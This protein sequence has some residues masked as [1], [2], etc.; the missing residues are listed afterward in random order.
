MKINKFEV[1]GEFELSADNLLTGWFLTP[2]KPQI[3]YALE[4]DMTEVSETD[5]GLDAPP[6]AL[7]VRAL[8]NAD[9]NVLLGKGTTIILTDD[10]GRVFSTTYD[11]ID[12]FAETVAD[13]EEKERVAMPDGKVET[14]TEGKAEGDKNESPKKG[15]GG[16][17]P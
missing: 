16:K 2:A 3:K 9:D 14:V 13:A 5:A 10:R 17:K 6:V 15:K 4:L 1:E 12:A 11:Q 8:D 7:E